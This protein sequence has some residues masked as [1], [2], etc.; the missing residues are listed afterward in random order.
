M[1]RGL[2][3]LSSI[4]TISTARDLLHLQHWSLGVSVHYRILHVGL[5]LMSAK[6]ATGNHGNKIADWHWRTLLH[7]Q[8]NTLSIEGY[9]LSRLDF[10]YCKKDP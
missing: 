7:R 6:T 5:V 8:N 1:L 3:K 10:L 9:K 2:T 4:Q